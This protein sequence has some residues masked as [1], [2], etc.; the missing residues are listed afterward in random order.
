MED[1]EILSVGKI[2]VN[3]VFNWLAAI[4]GGVLIGL[5][6]ALYAG[7]SE[8]SVGLFIVTFAFY[9]PF[10]GAICGFTI[11]KYT[12]TVPTYKVIISDTVSLNEFYDKY[13]VLEQDGKIYTIKERM[14]DAN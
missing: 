9:A 5:I 1:V 12:D 4:I 2:D 13:E 7:L 11:E 8:E 14:P 3:P 10:F 6:P